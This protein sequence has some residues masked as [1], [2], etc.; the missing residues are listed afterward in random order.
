VLLVEDAESISEP[1]ARGLARARFRTQ[2]ARTGAEAIE[3][4]LTLKPDVVLLDLALPDQD[5]R[6]VCRRLRQASD[7]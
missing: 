2:V 3:L 4:A 6:D 7:A 5:G 1:L